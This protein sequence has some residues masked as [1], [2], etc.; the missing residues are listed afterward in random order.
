MV[1][2]AVFFFLDLPG[3]FFGLYVAYGT[4]SYGWT[5]FPTRINKN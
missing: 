1:R 4:H 2:L 5:S 3:C